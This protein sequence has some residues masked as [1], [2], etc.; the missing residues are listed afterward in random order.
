M[1]AA[2]KDKISPKIKKKH[3]KRLRGP[4]NIWKL[5][6]GLA[7]RIKKKDGPQ[8]CVGVQEKS[9]HILIKTILIIFNER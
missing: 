2:E 9:K 6:L 3:N 7:K 1:Q 8:N 5:V 4:E